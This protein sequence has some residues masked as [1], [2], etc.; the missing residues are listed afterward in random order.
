MTSLNLL[1]AR[2]PFH[3]DNFLRLPGIRPREAEVKGDL[4]N[5]AEALRMEAETAPNYEKANH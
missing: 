4:G 1:A 3:G 5:S 2:S